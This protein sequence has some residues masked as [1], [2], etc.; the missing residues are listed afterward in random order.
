VRAQIFYIDERAKRTLQKCRATATTENVILVDGG[1]RKKLVDAGVTG[2]AF[3]D[4]RVRHENKKWSDAARD[5]ILIAHTLPPMRGELRER[6]DQYLCKVCRRGG[7]M[8]SP[9]VPYREEDLIGMQDFNVTWEWFGEFWPEDKEKGKS[10]GWPSPGLLVT[11]KVMNIFNK[12]G[13]K[14]FDWT[15]VNVAP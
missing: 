6:D 5:Q 9:D 4:V 10:A 14:A 13:V 1:I 15:P 7:R 3:G 8:T 12:A 11:P 2:I